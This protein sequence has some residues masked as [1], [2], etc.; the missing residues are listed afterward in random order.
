MFFITYYHTRQK[1]EKS[2]TAIQK[3]RREGGAAGKVFLYTHRATDRA[4]N[5]PS[6]S[7]AIILAPSVLSAKQQKNDKLYL[8]FAPKLTQYDN[9]YLLFWLFSLYRKRRVSQVSESATLFLK[10][11]RYVYFPLKNSHVPLPASWLEQIVLKCVYTPFTPVVFA[12]FDARTF[13]H[14]SG[15]RPTKEYFLTFLLLKTH[16]FLPLYYI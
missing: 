6:F 1:N 15:R 16:E 4:A 2:F 11:G 8:H 5:L 9:L 13:I 14:G 10:N 3:W 7:I 12:I